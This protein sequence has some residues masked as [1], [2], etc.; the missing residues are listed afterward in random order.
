MQLLVGNKKD[1]GLSAISQI[2]NKHWLKHLIQNNLERQNLKLAEQDLAPFEKDRAF[3]LGKTIS[4]AQFQTFCLENPDLLWAYGGK[5]CKDQTLQE[6]CKLFGFADSKA[7][8]H[9]ANCEIKKAMDRMISETAKPHF[10][11]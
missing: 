9:R 10:A 4:D 3:S 11:K 8:L 5:N 2:R 6:S 1:P 7:Q